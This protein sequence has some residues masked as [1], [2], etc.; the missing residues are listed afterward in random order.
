VLELFVTRLERYGQGVNAVVALDLDR[1]FEHSSAADDATAR[2]ASWGPLHGVP[3][4]VKDAFE[5]A[6]LVTTS[7][8]L[9]LREH[10][11]TVDAV[12]VARLREAGAVIFGKTNLPMFSR[13]VQTYNDLYGTTRNP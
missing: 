8:A 10:V 4:T 13:D 1:A 12:A 6:G 7:G 2:G 9:S 11:P 3:M 5:T